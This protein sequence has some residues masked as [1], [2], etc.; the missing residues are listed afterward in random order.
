MG[1]AH[2]NANAIDAQA[3][4]GMPTVDEET[5]TLTRTTHRVIQQFDNTIK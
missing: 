1:K 5:N 3:D 4:H 2:D